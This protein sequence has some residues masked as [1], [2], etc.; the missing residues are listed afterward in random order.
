MS[1]ANID[2]IIAGAKDELLKSGGIERKKALRDT[3]VYFVRALWRW[4]TSTSDDDGEWMA[5]AHLKMA[6]LMLEIATDP[7]TV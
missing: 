4:F 2:A 1:Q 6:V 3:H 5:H 7:A